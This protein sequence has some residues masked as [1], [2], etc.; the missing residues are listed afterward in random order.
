MLSREE[1][2]RLRGL[3]KEHAE[4]IGLHVLAAYTL[5]QDDPKA[6][7]AHA[8]WV[9][10]QASR[11]DF[12][13]ET[14]AFIAYRQGDWKLALREFRT[15]Y[16]MNG[17][18]DY[19][20]FIADCERGLGNPKK[21]IEI[22]L[23]DDAKRLQGESKAELFLVYA[24][25]LADLE[26]WDTAINVV[27]QLGRSKGLEGPYRMRAIQAEQF[28]LE[29]AGRHDEAAELN[30]LL[31]KLEEQYAEMDDSELSDVVIDYD[32]E[33]LPDDMLESIGIGRHPGRASDSHVG[34]DESDEAAKAED[35]D[36]V[37]SDADLTGEPSHDSSG[38]DEQD[39]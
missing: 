32:L 18:A 34:T 4:N 14:L 31:D 26:Q 24:G 17:Y 28:F 2:E 21:A 1:K 13:R 7:L 30:E 12:A 10:R 39:Q 16:R 11:V 15:A 25:A 37:T 35:Q 3:S 5:E 6:A 29:G 8:V 33:H 36:T 20:P 27:H 9:A 19:L 23:S 22:A 38:D